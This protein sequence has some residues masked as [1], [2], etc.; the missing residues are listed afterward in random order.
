MTG[1]LVLDKA[2]TGKPVP[3]HDAA[4]F[5][6]M[7]RAGQLAAL[8][9]DHVTPYVR[10]RRQHGR[11]RPPDRA[12]HAR[13]WRPPRDAQLQGLPEEQLHLGQP[14]RQPRHPRRAT[15]ACATAT[16]STS[17][18]PSSSTAGTATPAACTYAGDRVP[19]KGR[20]LTERTYEAMWAGIH[21]VRPGATLDEV[22]WAIQTRRRGL[23]RRRPFLRRARLRRP[24]PRPQL[25]RRARGHALPRARPRQAQ[26]EP[27]PASPACCSPSSP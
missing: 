17:T 20:L 6:A 1:S 5:A 10:R 2:G 9:L 15:S 21:A 14:R 18:S 3:I 12:L 19:V 11:A 23:P 27:R 8:T 26:A 22:G 7:R 4:A 25:P 16:S 24:R 13:A